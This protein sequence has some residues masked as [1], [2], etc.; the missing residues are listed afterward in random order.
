MRQ[1]DLGRLVNG[2]DSS[3]TIRGLLF[4]IGEPVVIGDDKGPILTVLEGGGS[5]SRY[6]VRVSGREIGWVCGS[7]RISPVADLL[8]HLAEREFEKRLLAGET[9]ERYRDLS[10][11]YDLAE[12]LP[13]FTKLSEA[14]ASTISEIVRLF[15]PAG[16]SVMLLNK[17]TGR[18][19]ILQ[20]HGTRRGPVM[21]MG[22]GEGIAG[23][24]LSSGRAEMVDD[25]ASEPRY[26]KGPNACG[27]LL[28][29]PLKTGNAVIGVI[30]A[31]RE[32]PAA[33]K[34]ADLKLLAGLAVHTAASLENARLYEGMR[35]TFYTILRTLAETIEK[36]DYFTSGHTKR[37]MEYSLAVGRVLGLA[38][39]DMERLELAGML[40][41]I[42]VIGV[43]D[44]I[45]LKPAP[46]SPE[47][48]TEMKKHPLYGEEILSPIKQLRGAIQGVRGHHER[49]DGSG[50]PDGLEGDDID[51]TAGIIAVA[52]SFDA[53]TSRRPF[54][55]ELSM[56]HAFEE[57]R[58]CSGTL[59]NPEVVDAFFAADVMEAFFTANSRK[60]IFPGR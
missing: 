8:S 42:G 16:A 45:L 28:C 52:D 33:Y 58:R 19:E 51:I 31:S 59:Y 47:E 3:A 48:F 7:P 57:I 4:S 15:R 39:D 53:M 23:S 17:E 37:V 18:L 24:V 38:G 29:V 13:V 56:D 2:R 36:R 14:A 10:L 55:L 6:A 5:G 35:E 34:A 30:N 20:A 46:L 54:R 11:I 41:D 22:P 25:V 49:Y 27:C 12:R 21:D 50:Y 43:R 9:L 44:D 40:H 32:Q 60:K 26:L 1:I